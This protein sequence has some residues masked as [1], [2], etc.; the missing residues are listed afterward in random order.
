MITAVPISPSNIHN[1]SDITIF[2]TPIEE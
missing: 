1:S 2:A